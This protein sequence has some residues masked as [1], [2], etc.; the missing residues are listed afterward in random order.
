MSP[1]QVCMCTSDLCNA[2]DYNFHTERAN[3]LFGRPQTSEAVRSPFFPPTSSRSRNSSSVSS[4]SSRNSKV[5]V[6]TPSSNLVEDDI[7]EDE[8][9]STQ[10]VDIV[11]VHDR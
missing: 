2:N 7:I 5:T 11:K 6:V 9:V 8:N 10:E 1:L 3:R 4:S